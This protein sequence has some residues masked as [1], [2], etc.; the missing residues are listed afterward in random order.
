M[1]VVGPKRLGPMQNAGY[2]RL[3]HE[4]LSSF[5]TP[6]QAENSPSNGEEGSPS[7]TSHEELQNR[8]QTVY[9]NSR[10]WGVENRRLRESIA[11]GDIVVVHEERELCLAD[12]GA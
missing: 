7:S 6:N 4:F 1:K 11:R 9:A 5:A 2:P 3:R 8:L 10:R 12:Q